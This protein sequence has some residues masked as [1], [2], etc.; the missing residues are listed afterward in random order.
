MANKRDV[1]DGS[2]TEKYR[3]HQQLR[4][5]EIRLIRI[6][7]DSEA[8]KIRCSFVNKSLIDTK[9]NYNALSYVWGD[10]SSKVTICCNGKNFDITKN[11]H[12]ALL[13]LRKN[14]HEK[15]LWV[16]AIC[17]DQSN[18]EEK[19]AQ[20]RLMRTIYSEAEMVII[21]LGK[22]VPTDRSGYELMQK[23]QSA[24]GRPNFEFNDA[25]L[26]QFLDLHAL[27]LPD[28]HD[29]AWDAAVKIL[30][31]PWF[32]RVW[33]V[34]ELLVARRSICLCGKV[35]VNPTLIIEFATNVAKFSTSINTI[36]LRA[37]A[38]FCS[39][40]R[41]RGNARTLF[42]LGEYE[43]RR[44]WELLV[45]TREFEAS[46][47]RDKVFALV[48]LTDDIADDF[49]DYGRSLRQ[50]LV[51]VAIFALTRP[52]VK[53]ARAL[54]LLSYAEARTQPSDLPTW[55][56]DWQSHGH[57]TYPLSSI[58]LKVV[59]QGSCSPFVDSSEV[60]AIFSSSSSP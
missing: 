12:E 57:E 11:L 26:T 15:L 33:I 43:N 27:G 22:E 1:L 18:N 58:S 35:E 52:S 41:S 20:V 4:R 14:A 49:I 28:M 46:D 38:T 30:S 21:W 7:P 17:I 16:D 13:Q 60:L 25:S 5:G 59:D 32:S 54:D 53:L 40:E 56:P 23:V 39:L 3:Y 45:S 44:L 34:Q 51:D 50:I 31:R 2:N 48:A 9:I 42:L 55:V 36:S 29:P 19:T 37:F 8:N 10:Q 6:E 47:L 24:L